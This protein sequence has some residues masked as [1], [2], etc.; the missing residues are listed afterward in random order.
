MYEKVWKVELDFLPLGIDALFAVES[1][2]LS[3]ECFGP[4]RKQGIVAW[5]SLDQA[6]EL[7]N[8]P[9][10]APLFQYQSIVSFFKKYSRKNQ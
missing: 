8:A 4:V 7:K 6:F 5:R 10:L 2:S 1:S 9:R 3:A